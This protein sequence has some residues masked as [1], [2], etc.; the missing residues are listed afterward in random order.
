VKDI[1]N[2]ISIEDVP[3]EWWE[4]LY[5]LCVD[6]MDSPGDYTGAC[7]GKVLA[8]LFYEP[9]TR[10]NFSF[11]SAMLRLGGGVFGFAEPNATSSAKGETLADTVRIA[12]SY[13]D[14]VVLRSPLEGAALAASMYSDVPIIN[15]G[16]GGHHHPTQTLTD[17]TTIA[18]LRGGVGDMTIGLCGD[19][20]YGRTA[21]SL[22]LALSMFPGIT[23]YL[24]S[25]PELRAPG[26]I[27]ARLRERGA[28]YREVSDM[29]QTL[30]E[31]DILYMTRIQRER[32]SD[33]AQYDRLRGTYVLDSRA[34]RAARQDML[35]MH[36]LP[37][38]D[39]IAPD[40][41]EDP[42]AVYFEQARYGMFIR[43]ALLL[44]LT[45]L[46]RQPPERTVSP[47]NGARGACPNPLCVTRSETYL[48]Q[49]RR[50]DNADRCLYCD[51]AIAGNAR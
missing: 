48:P 43:M 22:I 26:Y 45:D 3:V 24:I 16:D 28:D 8:T 5:A 20:R 21:H 10:T 31:L 1:R 41:D 46:P 34:M 7:V 25:P 35:V 14:A 12:G 44:T 40:V 29:S 18:R 32:F 13:A 19:L 2:L 36:P 27:T 38:L 47:A 30:P 17:L 4:R 51:C 6:I 39:E 37:K 11:Q 49:R 23:Y 42:R 33:P 50:P 9:S 15:A